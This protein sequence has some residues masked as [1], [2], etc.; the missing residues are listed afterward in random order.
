MLIEVPSGGRLDPSSGL[1]RE[2]QGGDAATRE[3][4]HVHEALS[5]ASLRGLPVVFVCEDN[6]YAIWSRTRSLA[7]RSNAARGADD[8]LRTRRAP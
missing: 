7:V 6:V 3:P 2:P 5:L 1:L 8:P 4:G